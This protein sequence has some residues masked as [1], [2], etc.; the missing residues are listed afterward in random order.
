[1]RLFL[2]WPVGV[3][4]SSDLTCDFVSE[5]GAESASLNDEFANELVPA[6]GPPEDG[7]EEEFACERA[8]EA[9]AEEAAGIVERPRS[10][11]SVSILESDH[12]TSQPR[13][14][15]VGIALTIHTR[16]K[17][18]SDGKVYLVK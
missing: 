16:G 7:A 11:K 12:S 9:R 3:M 5:R 4:T 8:S 10:N 14:P 18:R 1:M 13:Q 15:V 2:A 17:R 6:A